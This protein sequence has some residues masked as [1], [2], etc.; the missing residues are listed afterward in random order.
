MLLTLNP[1]PVRNGAALVVANRLVAG[2]ADFTRNWLNHAK[3][4]A[5]DLVIGLAGD[6]RSLNLV[7][8]TIVPIR[9]NEYFTLMR[10]VLCRFV[11]EPGAW[12]KE[13]EQKDYSHHYVVMETAPSVSPKYVALECVPNAP[14]MQE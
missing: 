14:H 8:E 2:D 9:L 10:P 6:G 5:A 1:D 7:D 11:P 12:G 13:D 4:V 3:Q